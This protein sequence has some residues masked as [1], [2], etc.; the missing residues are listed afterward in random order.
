VS[1]WYAAE[2][3]HVQDGCVREFILKAESDNIEVP[4]RLSDSREERRHSRVFS[5]SSRGLSR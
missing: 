2:M 5:A 4:Q 1:D 3:E